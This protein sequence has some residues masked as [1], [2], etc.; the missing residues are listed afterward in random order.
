M[1]RPAGAAELLPAHA[2]TLKM[3]GLA[4]SF[5]R[6]RQAREEGWTFRRPQL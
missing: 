5:E 6:A 3:P 4:R 2:R 1:S